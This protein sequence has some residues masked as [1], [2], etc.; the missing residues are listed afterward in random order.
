ME[1]IQDIPVKK[2]SDIRTFILI[3]LLAAI[4]VYWAALLYIEAVTNEEIEEL[5]VAV[6]IC[7]FGCFYIGWCFPMLWIPRDKKLLN[8][9]ISILAIIVAIGV[10]WL[11][12]HADF[13]LHS[14]PA[15]NL[16][17]YW[18]PF[19]ILSAAIG[20]LVNVI[21]V[22]VRNQLQ[23]ANVTAA[24]SLSELHLLQSQLSPHF[25]FNTLNNLYGLSLTQHEKIPT[26]LLKL[27]DLLRYSVYDAK[28]LFVPLKEEVAYINNYIDFEKI[29]IGD[30]LTLTTSIET[31]TG[32]QIKIAPMLLIVFIENAFK[33]SKNTIEKEVVI[34]I[35]LKIWGDSILFSVK[36]SYSDGNDKNGIL[37]NGSGLGLTNVT[38]RLQLLYHNQYHLQ[39]E[40]KDGSYNVMLQLKMK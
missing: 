28:E 2:R 35:S 10:I 24:N 29:R 11:F 9:I 37:K 39:V 38:K 15:I 14:M 30:R 13:P 27:S 8:Y 22:T 40:N 33:H 20:A 34:D 18:L 6:T 19:I 17:L 1:K 16:L 36:N 25:L 3:C 21:R 5:A 12:A 4:P 7:F 23:Q 31:I 26:L 32:N